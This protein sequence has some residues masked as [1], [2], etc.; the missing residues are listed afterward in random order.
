MRLQQV[1]QL[2]S[3]KVNVRVLEIVGGHSSVVRALVAKARVPEF[4]S[5]A[6]TKTFHILPLLLS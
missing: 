6:M 1:I 4:D 2:N 5:L 3:I